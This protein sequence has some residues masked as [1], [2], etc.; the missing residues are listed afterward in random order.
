MTTASTT[1]WDAAV[2]SASR[3]TS[4]TRRETCETPTSVNVRG[5]GHDGGLLGLE[6]RGG[7]RSPSFSWDSWCERQTPLYFN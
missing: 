6:S 5:E 3:F 2:T 1:R 4:S 7:G